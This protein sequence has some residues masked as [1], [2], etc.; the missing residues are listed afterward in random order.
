FGVRPEVAQH[1][2]GE[3]ISG[4]AGIIG[5]VA[6]I[7]YAVEGGGANAFARPGAL[8][9]RAELG[10]MLSADQA[11]IVGKLKH[12]IAAVDRPAE[13]D[14]GVGRISNT[15]EGHLRQESIGVVFRMQLAKR[16]VVRLFLDAIELSGPFRQSALFRAAESRVELIQNG[17]AD[18]ARPAE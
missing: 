12:L 6:E 4:V 9:E 2:G 5:V 10:R 18:R 16:D 11:E 1:R 7:E 15:S 14:G 8:E 3:G 13:I 17:G